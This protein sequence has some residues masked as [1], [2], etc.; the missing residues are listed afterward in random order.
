MAHLDNTKLP[1]SNRHRILIATY[2]HSVFSGLIKWNI[3][4]YEIQL[5][6]LQRIG[7]LDRTN[8]TYYW[9]IVFSAHKPDFHVVRTMS[10]S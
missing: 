1:V 5:M 3:R 4:P 7:E 2:L 10:T 9:L 8:H 6:Y